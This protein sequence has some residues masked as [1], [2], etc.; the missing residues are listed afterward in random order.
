LGWISFLW[1]F[2][3]GVSTVRYQHCWPYTC[4]L[5]SPGVGLHPHVLAEKSFPQLSY[6]S[7]VGTWL[8]MDS[9]TSHDAV[10]LVPLLTMLGAMLVPLGWAPKIEHATCMVVGGEWARVEMGCCGIS[11]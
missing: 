5:L 4:T 11:I 2:P 3:C 6:L 1:A 8:D 10:L 9:A 7:L